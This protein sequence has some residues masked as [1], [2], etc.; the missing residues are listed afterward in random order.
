[1]DFLE[2]KTNFLHVRIMKEFAGSKA[3]ISSKL[4]LPIGVR[5]IKANRLC[6]VSLR[7]K[8]VK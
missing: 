5:S 2:K 8:L 6:P 1:M 4:S 7:L 3:P